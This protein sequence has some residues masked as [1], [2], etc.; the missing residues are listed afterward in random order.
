M[1]AINIRRQ[2]RREE[3]RG[4]LKYAGQGAFQAFQ[5]LVTAA[6]HAT[7]SHG[8]WKQRYDLLNNIRHMSHHI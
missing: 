4:H 8:G 2:A 5:T 3:G 1:A 6:G 7:R